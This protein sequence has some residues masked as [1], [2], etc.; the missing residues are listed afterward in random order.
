MRSSFH[1]QAVFEAIQ[2]S[3]QQNLYV[4]NEQGRLVGRGRTWAATC[5]AVSMGMAKETPSA[6]SAFME[7]MPTTS[8]ARF[9]R[10]PPELPEFIAASVCMKSEF[11][12]A[13]PSSTAWPTSH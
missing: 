6:V 5:L 2:V 11:G 13:N 4:C 1:N 10:G 7:E 9:T 12:P 8:P 3:T